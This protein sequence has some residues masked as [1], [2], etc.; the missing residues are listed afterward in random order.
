MDPSQL[1][2][3]FK[4]LSDPNRLKILVSLRPGSLCAC[5]ILENL[6]ISQ[7]TLSHHMQVLLGADL[8][9]SWQVGKWTHYRLNPVGMSAINQFLSNLQAAETPAPSPSANCYCA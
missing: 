3:T 4:A 1:T 7:S 6:H 8:V 9:V 5:Q 2:T